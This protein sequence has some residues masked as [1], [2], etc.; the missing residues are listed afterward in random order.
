MELALGRLHRFSGI[1]G[2]A[3]CHPVDAIFL[4]AAWSDLGECFI[5]EIGE[6]MDAKAI[7]VSFHI[8]RAA[9]ALGQGDEFADELVGGLF[10]GNTALEF[11]VA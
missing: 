2:L 3:R 5:A 10:E 11:S 8:D 4:Y 7:L 9:V 6:E 1:G